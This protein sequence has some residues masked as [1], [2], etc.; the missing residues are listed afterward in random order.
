MKTQKGITL[1]ALIITII[2]MLILVGVSVTVAINTGLFTTASGVSK[3]TTDQKANELVISEGQANLDGTYTDI[4]GYVQEITKKTEE[5]LP[6]GVKIGDYVNYDTGADMAEPNSSYYE[7]RIDFN[8]YRDQ[9][10]N[11]TDYNNGWRV[12]GINENGQTLLIAEG[13]LKTK[14]TLK[15]FNGFII[16]S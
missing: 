8:G 5:I 14:L 16:R 4:E 6:G 3:N 9:K 15:R 2:V 13:V 1:I 12:L 11:L 7:S 10:F